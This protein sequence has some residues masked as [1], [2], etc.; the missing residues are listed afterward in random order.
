MNCLRSLGRWDRG[1]ESHSGHG[2]L[3]CMRLFCV[4]VVLCLGRGLATD[5]S[6]VQGVLPTVK[7]DTELNKSPG[8][9]MGWKSHWKKKSWQSRFL[10]YGCEN[11]VLHT[12]D[13][14]LIQQKLIFYEECLDVASTIMKSVIKY[15]LSWECL[16]LNEG[17]STTNSNGMNIYELNII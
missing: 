17:N 11:W 5:W 3:V 13:T 9:W 4:C 1:F 6:L 12:A 10:K 16:I 2:S 14:R 15:P 8:P 7:N